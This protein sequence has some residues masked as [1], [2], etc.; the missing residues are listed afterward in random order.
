MCNYFQ[1]PDLLP[2]FQD[3]QIVYRV[4]LFFVHDHF[5]TMPVRSN[6]SGLFG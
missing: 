3:I 1:A 6:E 5:S 2:G 4:R